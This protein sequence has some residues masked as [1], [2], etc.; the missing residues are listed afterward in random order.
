LDGKN[1]AAR[2][3]AEGDHFSADA[4]F[5]IFIADPA[6]HENLASQKPTETGRHSYTKFNFPVPLSLRVC[7]A[8]SCMIIP[9]YPA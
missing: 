7:A 1:F 4:K 2:R 3:A 9:Q 8:R 6:L 5:D